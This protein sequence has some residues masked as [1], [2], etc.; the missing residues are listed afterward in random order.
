MNFFK[1]N[2]NSSTIFWGIGTSIQEREADGCRDSTGHYQVRA[3]HS[4]DNEE[5]T[6]R[7][8][9]VI[10]ARRFSATRNSSFN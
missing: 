6:A 7:A 5:S 3:A 4:M 9:R 10:S 1:K 2:A 8:T